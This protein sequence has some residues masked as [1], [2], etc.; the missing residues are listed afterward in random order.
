MKHETIHS[1]YVH[2]P[3][4]AAKCNYCDF[5]SI[6]QPDD[7]IVGRYLEA[8]N[9]EL[10]MWADILARPLRS[11]FIGGGTPT[12]LSSENLYLLIGMMDYLCDDETEFT[13][14]SN[15]GTLDGEKIDILLDGGVNRVSLGVQSFNDDDLKL[16]GRIHD[17]S[18]ALKSIELLHSRGVKNFNL[19]LIYA[20]HGQSH[21]AWMENLRQAVDA[22]PAHLSCYSLIYEQG[23]QFY[24]RL[25]KGELV[26]QSD[27]DQERVYFSTIDFLEAAGYEHY[28][29]SNFALPG[30]R[31]EH[32]ITYWRNEGYVGIGP[33]AVSY[34]DAK[35]VSNHSDMQSWSRAILDEQVLPAAEV[36]SPD[37]LQQMAETL[38]MGLRLSDGIPLESFEK[39]FGESIEKA[40][41][42]T[43]EKHIKSGFLLVDSGKISI[44]K[45]HH[46]V[47]N[48]VLADF[49]TESTPNH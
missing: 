4:C 18:G 34:V 19:D 33:A 17:R 45:K 26:E 35:R 42:Q 21:D 12:L 9:V 40:F 6:P 13:I 23:T 43:L 25:L 37:R 41:P 1:L 44:P 49:I 15:P 28:E 29:T 2:V 46:F 14:E 16:L 48:S 36:E 30:R 7:E 47:A 27:A 20:I 11:I 31:C 22:S 24:T 32:N 39:R 10:E 3:F 8:I 38:M 5:Y